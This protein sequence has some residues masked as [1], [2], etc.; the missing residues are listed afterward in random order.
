[1]HY[2]LVKEFQVEL[3]KEFNVK[4]NVDD[5]IFLLMFLLEAKKDV[6]ESKV[7]TLIAMH[8]SHAASSIAA[9]V[10]VLSDDSKVQAFDMDL[11]KNVRIVYEELKEKDHKDRSGKRNFIDL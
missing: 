2:E 5:L 6:D 11:D 4:L 3:G 8:G 1:M 10:N 9:V 7:V